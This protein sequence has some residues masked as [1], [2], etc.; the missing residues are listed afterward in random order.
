MNRF[1]VYILT[2]THHTV[3]YTGFTDDLERRVFEHK[4]KLLPGFTNKYNC[5]KL[6]YI[7]EFSNASEAKHREHQVKRYSKA[8]KHNLI[9]TINHEWRDLYSDFMKVTSNE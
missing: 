1:W 5:N 2:N 4:N 9:N 8:W 3:L 7:E 6:V